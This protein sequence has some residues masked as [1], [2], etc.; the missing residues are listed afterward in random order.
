MEKNKGLQGIPWHEEFLRKDESDP[1]RYK[2][3]CYYYEKKYGDKKSYCRLLGARCGTSSFCDNYREIVKQGETSNY[4]PS[5]KYNPSTL[6][7]NNKSRNTIADLEGLK[8][9]PIGSYVIH[10]S[11]GI[12]EVK[13]ISNGNITVN[14][15]KRGDRTFDLNSVIENKLFAKSKK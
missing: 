9:F 13:E 7:D 1:K 2:Y 10:K 15:S 3:K 8:I 12:G 14:F 5:K 4:I 11:F 6:K